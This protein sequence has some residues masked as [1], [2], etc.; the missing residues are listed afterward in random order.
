MKIEDDGFVAVEIGGV[1][2]EVDVYDTY[3]RLIGYGAEVQAQFPVR[4]GDGAQAA[5]ATHE[6]L[7]RVVDLL[8]Q[9]GF[10]GVSKRAADKFD[11]ALSRVVD[12]LKKADADAPTPA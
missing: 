4:D 7:T 2:R 3:N 12:D 6:Y 5:R 8:T 9:L 1:T 11:A 10:V